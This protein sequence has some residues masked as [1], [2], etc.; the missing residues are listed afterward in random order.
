MAKGIWRQA[1]KDDPIYTGKFIISSHSK[2]SPVRSDKSNDEE[3]T[4]KKEEKDNE[5]RMDCL[6]MGTDTYS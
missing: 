1:S 2:R 6:R 5:R 4:V 3:V